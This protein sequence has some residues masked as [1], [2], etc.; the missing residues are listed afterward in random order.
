MKNKF[1]LLRPI[2]LI[3]LCGLAV[4]LLIAM[5]SALGIY[6]VIT[7][8][9]LH[10]PMTTFVSDKFNITIDYPRTWAAFEL[11][12]GSH[13]DNEVIAFFGFASPITRPKVFIAQRAFAN[14]TLEDIAN[15][16]EL[17]LKADSSDYHMVNLGSVT[18]PNTHALLRYYSTLSIT[19]MGKFK[20]NC[21]DWYTFYDSFGYQLSFCTDETHWS[22]ME[23]V[24][25]QMAQSFTIN[26]R[27]SLTA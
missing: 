15:W 17:R 13:G 10:S 4:L 9:G 23:N 6:R 5:F 22:E 8:Y 11:P 27:N 20:N 18:S 25:M 7:G 12:D 24:F 21:I 14:P 19:P 1:A 16:G 26:K 2:M 3:I